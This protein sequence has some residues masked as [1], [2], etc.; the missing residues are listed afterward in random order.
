VR[1]GGLPLFA[2]SPREGLLGQVLAGD[3]DGAGVAF[4]LRHHIDSVRD[5]PRV[6]VVD[7][8][9]N[10][11]EPILCNYIIFNKDVKHFQCSKNMAKLRPSGAILKRKCYDV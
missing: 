9:P 11:I 1:R 7:R 8:R 10:P 3:L 4:V 5:F 6:E 2:D